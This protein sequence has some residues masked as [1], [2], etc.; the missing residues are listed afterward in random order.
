[1]NGIGR[2]HRLAGLEVYQSGQPTPTL[3]SINPWTD[4]NVLC[5]GLRIYPFYR[6]VPLK[7]DFLGA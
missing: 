4:L 1:M 3:D 5:L 7:P 2:G 6:W